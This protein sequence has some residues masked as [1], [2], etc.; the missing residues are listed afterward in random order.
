MKEAWKDMYS[1][2]QPLCEE[3]V[4]EQYADWCDE[5]QPGRDM[6]EASFMPSK[7]YVGTK[8]GW[9]FKTGGAGTGYYRNGV[10]YLELNTQAP[11]MVGLKPMTLKLCELV[12]K[13][14]E[15][16]VGTR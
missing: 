10:Q 15:T 6:V 14:D 13:D 2:D 5:G 3:M 1:S 12:P 7:N 4:E 9:S 11:S 16:S 8:V